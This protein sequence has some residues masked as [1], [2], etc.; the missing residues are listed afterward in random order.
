MIPYPNIDPIFLQI[1]PIALRWYGLMYALAFLFATFLTPRIALRRRLAITP[2]EVSD[3]VFYVAIGVIVGGRLGY[4]F[5]YNPGYYM[6]HPLGIFAVW[7]GGMAFHGGLI[8]VIIA[9]GLFCWRRRL[10]FYDLADAGIVSVPVGLGLGRMGNF[11]NAEL[12]GRPTDV[13]WCMVFPQEGPACRHPSQLYQAGLEGIV[14]FT[15]LFGLSRR[16][17]PSGVI[18]W[19]FFLFYGLFRFIAEFFRQ[20]DAHI[21]LVWASFS[22]GQLLSLPMF[23]GGALMIG[24]RFLRA[25]SGAPQKRQTI[26]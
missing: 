12:V 6:S 5:I 10:S 2:T 17:L 1:G 18:F 26:P 23:I 19:A 14:L 22:M 8:G 24:W 15:I 9:G 3:L 20:P 4:V 21:G 25:P 16:A 7:E 13:P 11:I